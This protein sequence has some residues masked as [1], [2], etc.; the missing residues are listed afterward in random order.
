MKYSTGIEVKEG[1][2]V[3]VKED[4]IVGVV[5]EIDSH[6]GI[7]YMESHALGICVVLPQDLELIER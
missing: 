4:D 2:I 7:I 3:K 5:G 6:E 1:D